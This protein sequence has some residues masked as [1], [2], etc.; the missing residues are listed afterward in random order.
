[1]KTKLRLLEL[2]L[3]ITWLIFLLNLENRV[4]K[5]KTHISWSS[6]EK[7]FLAEDEEFRL[8]FTRPERVLLYAHGLTARLENLASIYHLQ[9]LS[10]L[11]NPFLLDCGANVGEVS[12]YVGSRYQAEIIAVEP[13]LA[14]FICLKRNL[15]HL[16]ATCINKLLWNKSTQISMYSKPDTADTSAIFF[17]ANATEIV[18]QTT[19]VDELFSEVAKDKSI[20]LKIEAE[21]AEPEVLG[22]APATIA[23]AKMIVIDGGPERGIAR[24]RTEP[25]NDLIIEEIGNFSKVDSSNRAQLYLNK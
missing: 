1:M 5:T 7:I 25:A 12:L 22:G 15:A 20:I 2:R 9:C 4:R 16:K 8:F 17:G 21:G 6:S 14:E 10:S 19:T 18:M 3:P 23:R 13:E 24:E 11:P